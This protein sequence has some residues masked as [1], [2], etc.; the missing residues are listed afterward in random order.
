MALSSNTKFDDHLAGI[1][2]TERTRLLKAQLAPLSPTQREPVVI[3]ALIDALLEDKSNYVL[4]FK[5][6]STEMLRTSHFI[7]FVT[8]NPVA[9][10]IMKQIMYTNSAKDNDGV[11]TFSFEDSRNFAGYFSQLSLFDGPIKE[12][13]RA[14]ISKYQGQTMTVHELC[15]EVDCDFTNQ[16][17]SKNVTDVLK[18]MELEGKIA[19][20]AGRKI[21][22][23]GGV[24]TMPKKA[25]I[26]FK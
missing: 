10:K 9:C 8:K 12:L 7:V 17:V 25:T 1:F 13:E 14:M 5:F 19:V 16:F 11:A 2:G 3:D 21:K 6:Y 26:L 4:P 18:R 20:V 23:R 24:P 22:V 15:D